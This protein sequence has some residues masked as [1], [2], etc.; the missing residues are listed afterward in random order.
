MTPQAHLEALLKAAE[1]GRAARNR[2]ETMAVNPYRQLNFRM[3]WEA[4]WWA[5]DRLI[6][7]DHHP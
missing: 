3:S 5:A 6:K 4:G 7:A 1:K 2:G